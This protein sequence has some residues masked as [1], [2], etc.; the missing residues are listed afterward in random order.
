MPPKTIKFFRLNVL[1]ILFNVLEKFIFINLNIYYTTFF[2]KYIRFSISNSALY[3]ILT[4]HK[5]KTQVAEVKN[6]QKPQKMQKKK[7]E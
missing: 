5:S 7:S 2:F 1:L 4:Q 6:L 3:M